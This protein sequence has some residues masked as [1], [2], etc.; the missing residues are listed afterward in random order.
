ME[1]DVHVE[2][3]G[4]VVADRLNGQRPAAR[5]PTCRWRSAGDGQVKVRFEGLSGDEVVSLRLRP[6]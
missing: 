2:D 5:R 6:P 3:A 1:T 4:R